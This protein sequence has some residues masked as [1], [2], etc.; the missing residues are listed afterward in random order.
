MRSR[1]AVLLLG[2]AVAATLGA[3]V[4]PLASA[5]SAGAEAARRHGFWAS[6]DGYRGWFGSWAL[7]GVGTVWCVDHGIA[8]PDA[9]YGY[10]PSELADRPQAAR[11]AMAWALGRHGPGADGVTSAALTLVLH[12]LMEA[13]YPSGPLDV[14]RLQAGR[15]SGF[16]GLERDVLD[17]ARAIKADGLA[18]AHLRGPLALT[19]R[20]QPARPG[21][22]GVLVARLTDAAGSG[23]A[24]VPLRATATGAA[25]G[26]GTPAVTDARGEQRF[27]FVAGGGENAFAVSGVVP[28]VGLRSLAPSRRRAQRVALPARVPVAAGA[29]F[30]AESRRLSVRK[31]GDASAYLPTT[32][33]RFRV[34]RLSGTGAPSAPVGELAADAGGRTSWMELDPGV[35]R[36]EEVAAPA[37]YLPGGPWTADLTRRSEV[38]VEASNRA[39]PGTARVTKVDA[40]TGRALAGAT[41]AL[42]YDADRDG[43]FETA[44]PPVVSGA[45]AAERQLP[46]GDYELRETAAPPG[47]RLA[48]GPVRFS[49]APGQATTVTVP[50]AALGAA[51]RAARTGPGASPPRPRAPGAAGGRGQRR[52]PGTGRP[53]SALA[54]TGATLLLAGAV[55]ASQGGRSSRRARRRALSRL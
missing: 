43:A 16:G 47:Y 35:Y 50:N 39:R 17:R 41:L 45:G 12:D 4:G 34:R 48:R 32:G 52:L 26:P 5:P 28:D 23:V 49:I 22:P 31:T 33:A 11:A 19:A 53:V 10:T 27:P 24:G 38:V 42:R 55:L 46:P 51:S 15:L 14:D 30:T 2:A 1:S 7:D 18:H 3:G 6:V 8:A 25:L 44:L 54:L 9:G 20:A 36:V 40:G 21:R 37:G 13:P 29:R